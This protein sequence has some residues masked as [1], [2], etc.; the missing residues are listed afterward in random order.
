MAINPGQRFII[1]VAAQADKSSFSLAQQIINQF[2][3]TQQRLGVIAQNTTT[4]TNQLANAQNNL[5]K[6]M[7]GGTV[8]GK[9]QSWI[10]TIAWGSALGKVYS[11]IASYLT[12]IIEKIPL[13]GEELYYM[14]RRLGLPGTA[15]LFNVAFAGSMI[16]LSREQTLGSVE[17]MAA[18]ARTNPGIAAL[19]R[20]F[21]AKPGVGGTF[22]PE[23][24][25]GLVNKL[26][27]LPYFIG[28]QFAQMMGM[29]EGTFRQMTTNLQELNEQ[30]SNHN[31]IIKEF[32]INTDKTSKDFV[33][34]DRKLTEIT[35]KIT[36]LLTE[37]ADWFVTLLGPALDT[38]NKGLENLGIA[39]GGKGL[40]LSPRGQ[41]A[42]SKF[43][44]YATAISP[45]ATKEE[46]LAAAQR[47]TE[48]TVG[49]TSV[50]P[51]FPIQK[52]VHMQGVDTRIINDLNAM[53]EAAPA[54]AKKGF[55]V[56]SGK[57]TWQ[58]QF[59]LS[60]HSNK[61]P[62]ASP[63]RSKHEIGE[64]VDISDPSGWFHKHAGEYG[65]GFPVP[66]DPPHMEL[67]NRH[68]G[69]YQAFSPSGNG[70]IKN[71]DVDINHGAPSVTINNYG[72]MDHDTLNRTRSL[73]D[74][75]AEQSALR[76]RIAVE[77]ASVR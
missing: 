25:L 13:M 51:T 8:G 49:G 75:Y 64:A 42:Q 44:Y 29:D 48:N 26:N 6:V 55:S 10:N 41:R 77:G 40:Q 23:N 4:I 56:T 24:Q 11:N 35:D 71:I 47:A 9:N 61:Y 7:G 34:F 15:S 16:G 57:R 45:F 62:V 5:N 72:T 28:A 68:P 2:A 52:G 43:E 17:S 39:V 31:K 30:Y 38:I 46:K 58:E 53:W 14:N 12:N 32:G 63:G 18:A 67:L 1:D 27:Q 19:M 69:S 50:T 59:Y 65:L 76:S 60:T 37:L 36:L 70:Q 20:Q 73:L 22:S 54:W 74:N 33:E 66:G 3:T 21:G